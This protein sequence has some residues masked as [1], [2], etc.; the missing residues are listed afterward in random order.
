[1]TVCGIYL[2]RLRRKLAEDGGFTVRVNRWGNAVEYITTGFALSLNPDYEVI[3]DPKTHNGIQ[4][5]AAMNE[6]MLDNI[7][8]LQRPDTY[9]GVWWDDESDLVYFD[10]S[11]VVDDRTK[12][13]ELG[14]EHKQLAVFDLNSGEE[15]RTGY[16]PEETNFPAGVGPAFA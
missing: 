5:M 12:A 16:Q 15:I 7:S 10:V 14:I 6:Y 1:V 4:V 8:V 9:F 3:I 2:T 13:I 11:T